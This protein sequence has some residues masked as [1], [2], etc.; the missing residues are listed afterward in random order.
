MK[1]IWI[2]IMVSS[3]LFASSIVGSWKVDKERSIKENKNI[4]PG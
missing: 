3:V 4:D 2:I 1:Y